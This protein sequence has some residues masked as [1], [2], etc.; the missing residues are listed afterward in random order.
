VNTGISTDNNS[1][2]NISISS[3]ATA[4]VVSVVVFVTVIAIILRRNKAKAKAGL[5]PVSMNTARSSSTHNMESMYED[6]TG[7]LQ[8]NA[9]YSRTNIAL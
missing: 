8:E 4:L 6:V 2:S 7:P 1:A 5:E 9:A 3:L